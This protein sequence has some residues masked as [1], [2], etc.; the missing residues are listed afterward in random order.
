PGQHGQ[1]DGSRRVVEYD[2][3]DDLKRSGQEDGQNQAKRKLASDARA[4]LPLLSGT[5]INSSTVTAE[6]STL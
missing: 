3:S 4:S 1:Q 5:M 6:S 2:G